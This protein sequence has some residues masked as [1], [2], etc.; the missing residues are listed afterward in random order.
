MSGSPRPRSPLAMVLLAMLAEQPMH[1]YRMQQLIKA[2]G[3]DTIANVARPN[4]VYQTI[5][6]LLRDG[7]IAVHATA[8]S[9]HR[10]ERTTYEITS[11]GTDTL[12]SWVRSVLSTPAREF[13]DFP[14]ALSLLPLLQPHDV[15]R[16]LELRAAALV[17][18]LAEFDRAPVGLPRLFL[19]ED[20]YRRIVT[21]AELDWVRSVIQDLA[22]GQFTWTAE[23]LREY[24]DRLGL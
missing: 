6:R 9:E 8:R 11:L 2:R 20:E 10:P 17:D 21:R 16:L 3:K 12:H 7:L 1:P 13:P 22:S 23:W 14:A 24:A 15:R 18:R 19:I 5:D 4:S